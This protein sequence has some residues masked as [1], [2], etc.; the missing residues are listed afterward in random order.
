LELW[1][2]RGRVQARAERACELMERRAELLGQ[3]QDRIM[4]V[5]D[6]GTFWWPARHAIRA[7]G[8]HHRRARR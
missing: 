5:E 4:I 7:I 1:S 2:I 6:T 8:E 3:L